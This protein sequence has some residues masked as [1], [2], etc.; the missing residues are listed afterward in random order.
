MNHHP[1]EEWILSDETLSP[2]ENASVQEHLAA[3]PECRQLKTRWEAAKLQ[4]N[5]EGLAAPATGFT[6]RWQ[7][8][9]PDRISQLETQSAHRFLFI[10]L[11]CS[12][13][14]LAGWVFTWLLNNPTANIATSLIKLTANAILVFQGIKFMVFPALRSIPLV[15]ILAGIS[16]AGTTALMLSAVWAGAIWHYVF[17]KPQSL[18]LVKEGEKN[19]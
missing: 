13:A 4:I 7:K 3:C 8:N 14:M 9:L 11:A 16:I 15:Y 17:R 12:A 10:I 6:M 5:R 19:K 1:Y 2:A 18:E